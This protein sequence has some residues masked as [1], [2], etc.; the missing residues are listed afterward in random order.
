MF[1]QLRAFPTVLLILLSVTLLEKVIFALFH[2]EQFHELSFTKTLQ[3]LAW[4]LK[5]D[6]AISA[7]L[8]L[9]AYILAYLGTR[10]LRLKFLTTL[11]FSTFVAICMLV[12]LHGAD[13][14]YYEEV[15][16]HLGYE[17]RDSFN[18]GLHWLSPR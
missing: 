15:G 17:L 12:I 18:S 3:A 11:K 6:L 1:Q 5:F 16:R 10:L 13:M 14:L 7:A 2:G 4:G 9:I 8:C